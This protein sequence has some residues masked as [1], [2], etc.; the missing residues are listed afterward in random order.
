MMRRELLRSTAQPFAIMPSTPTT[1][2]AADAT[3][4]SAPSKMRTA[5]VILT[6]YDLHVSNLERDPSEI[7]GVSIVNL[8]ILKNDRAKA[9]RFSTLTAICA[10]LDCEIGELLLTA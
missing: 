4:T 8:S 2:R 9:I 6:A 1:V 5:R 3:A 10:A 7:V